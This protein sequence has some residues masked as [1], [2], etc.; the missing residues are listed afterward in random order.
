MCAPCSRIAPAL[1]VLA[2]LRAGAHL[3]ARARRTTA[4]H[5]YRGPL[6][7]TGR[8]PRDRRAHCR[9][10]TSTLHRVASAPRHPADL[11]AVLDAR[12]LCRRCLAACPAVLGH[13]HPHPLVTRADEVA[14][15]AHLQP[16]DLAIAADRCATVDETHQVGRVVQQQLGPK[17]HQAPARRTH[18]QALA[19]DVHE[20]VV[21][22]RRYLAARERTAEQVAADTARRDGWQHDSD[23]IAAARR[24]QLATEHAQE[25]AR[26]GRYLTPRERERVDRA[27]GVR[28]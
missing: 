25:K 5:L 15:Y 6:T 10:R 7:A 3:V 22:R 24:E 12:P 9:A 2:A 21:Q 26:Q 23:R 17:P 1:R 18:A 13:D 16:V 4:A 20:R 19:V 8:V 11:D 27:A 28:A 14:T